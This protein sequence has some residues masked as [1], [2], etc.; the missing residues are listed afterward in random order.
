MQQVC[1]ALDLDEVLADFLPA[2]VDWVRQEEKKYANIKVEDFKTYEFGKTLDCSEAQVQEYM[3]RFKPHYRQLKPIRGAQ[4]AIWRLSQLGVFR[5]V[6]VTARSHIFQDETKDWVTKHF[7]QI[8]PDD[9]HLTNEHALEGKKKTKRQVCQDLGASI[10]VDDSP[11]HTNACA[12]HIEHV[13]LFDLDSQYQWN[14]GVPLVNSIVRV[15][16]WDHI[17]RFMLH[18]YARNL[19]MVL[20]KTR[21]ELQTTREEIKTD[22]SMVRQVVGEMSKRTRAFIRNAETGRHYTE[23]IHDQHVHTLKT[24]SF[25]CGLFHWLVL[26]CCIAFALLH[27]FYI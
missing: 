20:L 10:F 17:E 18:Q 4:D 7:D 16:S 11:L 24:S 8:R 6:I 9:I 13:L 5:F 12:T 14:H 2:W 25:E 15:H 21:H 27:R 23:A 3:V 1:V 26:F 19:Q 22:T